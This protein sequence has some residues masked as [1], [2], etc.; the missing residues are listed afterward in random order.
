LHLYDEGASSGG[1]FFHLQNLRS[2]I[3]P[4]IVIL[5]QTNYIERATTP[6]SLL[7][8]LAIQ[9]LSIST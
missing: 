2:T 5:L 9:A 3:K 1:S 6:A 4:T 8:T 7:N